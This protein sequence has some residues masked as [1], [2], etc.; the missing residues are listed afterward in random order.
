MK[1]KVTILCSPNFK[2]F[3][4]RDEEELF[5]YREKNRVW[6]KKL[7]DPDTTLV[8]VA[9][10][11][12]IL[13]STL[14]GL[15]TY[16]EKGENDPAPIERYR[17][18]VLGADG[19]VLRKI[20]FLE[21]GSGFI[22]E[23]LTEKKDNSLL[24]RLKP[25]G[26]SRQLRFEI[27]RYNLFDDSEEQVW[28]FTTEHGKG[29][30][31][32]A[33][34]SGLNYLA[35]AEKRSKVFPGRGFQT[36]VFLYDLT[37]G[38]SLYNATLPDAQM[39]ELCLSQEGLLFLRVD[40]ENETQLVGVYPDGRKF[41]ITP[42]AVDPHLHHV[43]KE[44]VVLFDRSRKAYY[45]KTFD[46]RLRF[47]MDMQIL[48]EIKAQYT[49]FFRPNDDVV[50]AGFDQAD[51]TFRVSYSTIE[52]LQ[53]EYK[54]WQLQAKSAKELVV[55][56]TRTKETEIIEKKR[57]EEAFAEKKAMFHSALLEETI[58][59]KSISLESA[60]EKPAASSEAKPTVP[61]GG[62]ASK[63]PSASRKT[64]VA[65][66]LERVKLQLITGAISELE[67]ETK[68][69]ELALQLES[70]DSNRETE[71]TPTKQLALAPL[72]ESLLPVQNE[73]AEKGRLLELLEKIEE[74]FIRGEVTESTYLELKRKYQKKLN[75]F[76]MSEDPPNL[77]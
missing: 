14:E 65:K 74:R 33:A 60:F 40:S 27:V 22:A 67:A 59:P 68:R 37:N 41:F 48:D 38:K 35:A 28:Q 5:L 26:D 70:P 43:G 10:N 11:G 31:F 61:S 42:A 53:I 50:L 2:F 54:R 23:K 7:P 12:T 30:F 47:S 56:E 16:G 58:K 34:T 62:A 18:A 51:D 69:N 29:N 75:D 25:G 76:L 77:F 45:F 17:Q 57:Q 55:Q 52:D 6:Q 19:T 9:N 39:S 72:D 13:V 3:A 71:S 66:E 44:C 4:G 1:G 21:Q 73:S 64:E 46:D 20:V 24:G 36:Q 15:F 49:L 32:W 8:G 63:S